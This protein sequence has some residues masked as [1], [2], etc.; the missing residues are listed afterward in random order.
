MSPSRDLVSRAQPA[1]TDRAGT[2]GARKVTSSERMEQLAEKAGLAAASFNVIFHVP[3]REGLEVRGCGNAPFVESCI[4]LLGRIMEELP[5]LA[6]SPETAARI[7]I[8][9]GGAP[10]SIDYLNSVIRLAEPG[11]PV[12]ILAGEAC[13]ALLAGGSGQFMLDHCVR[14]IES[15]P[16]V[17]VEHLQIMESLDG[18]PDG[19]A[20]LRYDP[21]AF[22][23]FELPEKLSSK[24]NIRQ[25][26]LAMMEDMEN[27]KDPLLRDRILR[28]M[29]GRFIPTVL[30]SIRPVGE[31]YGYHAARDVFKKYFAGFAE[32]NENL[33]LL[34]S[35]LPGLGKTHFTIS[36]A[37]SYANVTLILCEPHDLEKPLEKIIRALSGKTA[38]HFVLFFD[39]VD[40]RKI[41][42]Y[43]FRTNVGGSFV[44][45]AN[46][47]IVIASN[48]EFPANISS[49]G[50]GFTFPIFNEIT[51]QEMIGDFL[52]CL[53]MKSPKPELVSVIAA[54]YVEEFGQHLFEEL[55][56]RTL[57]RY[58]ERYNSD[59]A[60]RR[61]M[62]ELSREKVIPVPD[63]SCFYDA[64]QKVIE[65]LAKS[66]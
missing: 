23:L 57:V 7:R 18:M 38:R 43:Y 11:R 50:R 42:W 55:S 20:L 41:D 45:P 62:L 14:L 30:N 29:D 39:D 44:L 5:R 36:H 32:R 40:T 31:F 24:K 3:C 22:R 56:P 27:R 21:A 34:I 46:V 15:F 48:Y 63:A 25:S 6:S 64:N 8:C 66:V 61:K 9:M 33:P 1:L 10:D 2:M 28:H 54:D 19:E 16:A 12:E 35:S 47:T 59:M 4:G 49:R 51:C 53:G 58:L 52:V 37:L 60:K 13:Q 65:R 26:F 17:V